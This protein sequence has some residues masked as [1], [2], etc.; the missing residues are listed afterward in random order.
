MKYP[1]MSEELIGTASA[2]LV[3]SNAHIRYQ[4][5]RP[6]KILVVHLKR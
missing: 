5:A 4:I 3:P 6:P 2:P 1:E